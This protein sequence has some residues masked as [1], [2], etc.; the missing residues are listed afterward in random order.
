MTRWQRFVAQF[1]RCLGPAPPPA[2]KL[3]DKQELAEAE[4]MYR[5][6]ADSFRSE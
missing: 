1:E 2:P 5:E 4:E 3:P 6:L